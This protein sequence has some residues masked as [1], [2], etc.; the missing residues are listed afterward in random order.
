MSFYLFF[1]FDLFPPIFIPGFLL[2][3]I[4]LCDVW[5]QNNVS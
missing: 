3:D 5:M 4:F 1:L 2:R